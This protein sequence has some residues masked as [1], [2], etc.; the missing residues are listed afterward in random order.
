MKVH[1]PKA[2]ILHLPHFPYFLNLI[3]PP[4]QVYVTLC[5]YIVLIVDDE[6]DFQAKGKKN[7]IKKDDYIMKL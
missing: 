3:H 6:K 4:N 7:S 1:P 2:R 5:L